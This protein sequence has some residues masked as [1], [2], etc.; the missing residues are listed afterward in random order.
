M[1]EIVN[2]WRKDRSDSFLDRLFDV[3]IIPESMTSADYT[4]TILPVIILMSMVS[5]G[6]LVLLV[7]F[8]IAA[9]IASWVIGMAGFSIPILRRKRIKVYDEA[10]RALES[11][12]ATK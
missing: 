4:K 5:I 2:K 3:H 12:F 9:A 6:Y 8:G 7:K 10:G 1:F 11:I